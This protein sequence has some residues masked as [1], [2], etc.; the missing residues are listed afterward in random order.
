[1]GSMQGPGPAQGQSVDPNARVDKTGENSDSNKRMD[2][3]NQKVQNGEELTQDEQQEL[4]RLNEEGKNPGGN[5]DTNVSG[6]PT[7]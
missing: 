6:E 2:E 4:N 3:L 1:M 5:P 7:A